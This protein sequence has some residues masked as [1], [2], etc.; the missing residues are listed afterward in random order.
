MRTSVGKSQ[1]HPRT[2][3]A[4]LFA[5]AVAGVAVVAMLVSGIFYTSP[6]SPAAT[7]W[8]I[9]ASVLLVVSGGLHIMEQCEE[10]R[11]LQVARSRVRAR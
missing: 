3:V 2:R 4:A 10:C 6:H 11:Y 8:W 5:A 9:G 1:T 7:P